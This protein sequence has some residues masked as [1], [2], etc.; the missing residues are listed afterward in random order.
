MNTVPYDEQHFPP[1]PSLCRRRLRQS[2]GFAL[3]SL[4]IDP[5]T[6]MRVPLA[7]GVR[8]SFQN[9]WAF[10]EC[11]SA[12]KSDLGPQGTPAIKN[13]IINSLIRLGGR[14]GFAPVCYIRISVSV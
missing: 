7:A 5:G 8:V 3:T 6:A 1:L 10:S 13:Q 14:K 12:G 11:L 2:S 9:S 4:R